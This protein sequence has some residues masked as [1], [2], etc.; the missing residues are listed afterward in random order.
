VFL[1]SIQL[2]G[3][4]KSLSHTR[5]SEQVTDLRLDL[6]VE[7]FVTKTKNVVVCLSNLNSSNTKEAQTV[8]GLLGELEHL[9]CDHA[10]ISYFLTDT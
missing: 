9:Y 4:S 5:W 3:G 7:G 6:G 8:T 10:Q 2:S 1:L